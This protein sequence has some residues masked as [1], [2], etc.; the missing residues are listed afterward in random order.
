[1]HNIKLFRNRNSEFETFI[2]TQ[3]NKSVQELVKSKYQLITKH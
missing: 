3:R 2:I 1:M